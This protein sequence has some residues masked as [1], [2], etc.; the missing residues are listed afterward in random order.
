MTVEKS[1]SDTKVNEIKKGITDHTQDKDI[2]TPEFNILMAEN[3]AAGL[4]KADLITKTDFDNNLIDLNRKIV[5]NKTKNVVIK[6]ELNELAA[7]DLSYFEGKSHFEDDDTQNLKDCLIKVLNLL[8][9]L[10]NLL[11]FT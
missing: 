8:L 1:T 7:F 11:I 4:A 6:N 3:F 2:A 10:R 5:S 9:H